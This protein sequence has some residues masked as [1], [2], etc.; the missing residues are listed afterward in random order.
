MSGQPAGTYE[1]LMWWTPWASRTTSAAVD[2]VSSAGTQRV[3]VNQQINGG[4]WNSLGIFEFVG[5]GS[6]KITAAASSTASTC[7]DAVWF[8]L[9]TAHT[10]PTAVIDSITP[11]SAT[12][13]QTIAF[14]GHGEDA[15]SAI[16]AWQW[17]SNLDGVLS[18]QSSFS[19][20]LSTGTHTISFKV[21]NAGGYWSPSVTSTVSVVTLVPE[22]IIDNGAAG[23]SS[24]GGWSVSGAAGYYGTNSLWSR[25]GPTYTW[26]MSGQAAGSYEVLMWWTALS[27]RTS[28]ALVEITDTTGTT[29]VRVN[30]R[31][32]G[33]KWN[34]LGVYKFGN[35]GTVRINASASS[36]SS[37]SG[38]KKRQNDPEIGV[39]RRIDS[40][41][42]L[43]GGI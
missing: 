13:G 6:A 33:G 20:V 14:T 11:E 23:T 36:T 38:Y 42:R 29:E 22:I 34:S 10:V 12:E 5:S 19:K 17:S 41:G 32:N 9:I 21:K 2:I 37:T 8:K 27:T 1:V 25:S 28:S 7:A 39:H 16:T 4:Q 3:F 18:T 31:S 15:N 30:Q 43:R 35:T 24:T 40:D 26:Q